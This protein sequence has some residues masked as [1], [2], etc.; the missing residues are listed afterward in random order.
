M[1]AGFPKEEGGK[2]GP[3]IEVV[4]FRTPPSSILKDFYPRSFACVIRRK[5]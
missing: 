3:D 5:N 2:I 1:D 4:D